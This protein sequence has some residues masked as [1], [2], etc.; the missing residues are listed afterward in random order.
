MLTACGQSEAAKAVDQQIAAIG[1]VNIDS[2][3][4]IAAAEFAAAALPE[5]DRKQLK[6]EEQLTEAKT[7]YENLVN[8]NAADEI[9]ADITAIGDVSLES[10]D[11]VSKARKAY[12]GASDEVKA[13]VTNAADL[14]AAETKFDELQVTNVTD[15]ISAIG[16]VSLES[17]TT[18]DEAK[19]AF[20][21]LSDEQQAKVTN[22]AKLT[23]AEEQLKALKQA[24]AEQ[25]LA[26]M[27]KEE[28]KF[29][30]ATFYYPAGWKFYS[31]GSWVADQSCFIRPY[32]AQNDSGCWIRVI[33]NYTGDSWVF[34]QKVTILADGE[35]FYKS[36]NYYDITRDNGG[37]RVWEYIDTDASSDVDM[38]TAIANSSEAIIRFEG[39]EYVYDYTVKSSDKQIISQALQAYNAL[40]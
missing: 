34:F 32:L 15:K 9:I 27:T 39:R 38:L 13:L 37:G 3:E 22:A 24:Q 20:D 30:N 36:F 7:A 23:A 8:Q 6:N 21:D 31:D 33:Y 25:L 1:E 18:I 28:D 2:S 16:E 26:G 11:A 5:E 29:Q 12:D 35:K 4:A 40:N 19:E 14:E 17:G 10:K